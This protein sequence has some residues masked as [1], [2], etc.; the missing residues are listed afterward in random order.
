M[1]T[2]ETFHW[3]NREYQGA[4]NT[5]FASRRGDLRDSL[6]TDLSP[7]TLCRFRLGLVPGVLSRCRPASSKSFRAF[8]RA[9]AFTDSDRLWYLSLDG[10]GRKEALLLVGTGGVFEPGG[11]TR[12]VALSAVTFSTF[13]VLSI[14]SIESGAFGS[15]SESA[16]FGCASGCCS[17]GVKGVR[18][19]RE[20]RN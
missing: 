18:G 20:G 8:V 11:E 6:A 13:S 7:Y 2:P 17:N 1:L 4:Y 9:S 19:G 16:I 3:R 10:S 14:N 12:F 15:D 5:K